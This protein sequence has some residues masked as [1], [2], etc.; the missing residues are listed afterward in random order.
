MYNNIF[1]MSSLLGIYGTEI[2]VKCNALDARCVQKAE[3][4]ATA[5]GH[6]ARLVLVVPDICYPGKWHGPALQ[7]YRS[8]SRPI[9]PDRHTSSDNRTIVPMAPP[10]NK[11][12]QPA[13]LLV[14]TARMS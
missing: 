11:L 13:V 10:S 8:A 12:L 6:A 4:S 14:Q 2:R 9:D 7:T 5:R 1:A 3:E